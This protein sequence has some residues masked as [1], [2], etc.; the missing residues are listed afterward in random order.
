M[1]NTNGNPLYNIF[2]KN[3]QGKLTDELDNI[4]NIQFFFNY[5]KND[6]VTDEQKASLLEALS[7]KIQNNRYISSFFENNNKISIYIYLFDLFSKNNSSKTLKDASISLIEVLIANIQTGK[8]I[9]E[10]LFQKLSQIYRGEIEPT[11]KNLH[12]YLKLLQT[13]LAEIEPRTPKNYFACS[14]HCQFNVDMNKV[15]LEVGHSFSINLNFKISNCDPEQ[16]NNRL[17]NLVKIYFSNQKSLSFDLLYPYFIIVKEVGKEFLKP[18]ASDECDE[19][20]NLLI[21]IVNLKNT[22]QVYFYVNGEKHMTPYKI[23]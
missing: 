18:L 3:S 15:L 16:K 19:W 23:E 17:S 11:S 22:M 1:S 13:V 2:L 12:T 20:L 9:F 10:Y 8:D 14:G 6:K 21:T 5:I 7:S 4:N